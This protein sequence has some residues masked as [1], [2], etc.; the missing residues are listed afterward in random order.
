MIY[1]SNQYYRIAR[2]KLI[3]CVLDLKEDI[4]EHTGI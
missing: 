4:A 2:N 1:I 3:S